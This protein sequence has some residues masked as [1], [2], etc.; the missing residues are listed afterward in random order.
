MNKG[1]LIIG[2]KWTL[3]VSTV[4]CSLSNAWGF[5]WA[6]ILMW[7]IQHCCSNWAWFEIFVAGEGSQIP[8]RADNSFLLTLPWWV[9]D[10]HGLQHVYAKVDLR[11]FKAIVAELSGFLF[12]FGFGNGGLL[13]SFDSVP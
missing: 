10:L 1:Q 7:H 4:L 11:L 3:L 12:L 5:V 8:E 9:K 6:L 13:F 2:L